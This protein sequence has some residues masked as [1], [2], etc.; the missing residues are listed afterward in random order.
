MSKVWARDKPHSINVTDIIIFVTFSNFP[1]D[2]PVIQ[3][4]IIVHLLNKCLHLQPT[5]RLLDCRDQLQEMF[6]LL[7]VQSL[8]FDFQSFGSLLL[9]LGFSHQV[10]NWLKCDS[11]SWWMFEW[12]TIENCLIRKMRTKSSSSKSQLSWINWTD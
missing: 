10:N 3:F 1:N 6:L 4:N 5:I 8:V 2:K 11:I 9:T 7:I 12:I